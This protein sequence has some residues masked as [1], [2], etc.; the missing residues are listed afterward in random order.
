MKYDFDIVTKRTNTN[1]LKWGNNED[2][3]PMWVA[4]MDFLVAPEIKEAI[5][6]RLEH[7]I[8]GYSAVPDELY[9]SYVNWWNRRHNFKMK[10]EELLFCIGVMPAISSMIREFTK[11]DDNIIIQTP[12][13]HIFFKVIEDNNRNVLE[14]KL[15]FDGKNYE[16]DFE[17][18]EK[19]LSS[20]KSKMMLLCNPHNPIG[21]IWIKEEIEKIIGLCEKYNVLLVS[22]EIHCDLVDPDK[23]YIAAGR[24]SSKVITC[25]APTKTFNIAGIQSSVIHIPNKKLFKQ[26]QKRL[27]IDDS[28]QINVFSINATIAAF[29]DAEEWLNQLNE[30]IYHNK[31][32]VENFLADEIPEIRLIPCEA[33]Y[34][35]WLDCEKLNIKSNELS[36]FIREKTGLFLSPGR[37]FGEN[38][39]NFLRM[40][41]A[42]P[43]ETLL[44]G[45]KRLKKSVELLKEST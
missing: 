38:G 18:L 24:L 22:D 12:V 43:L 16:I 27:M 1:S 21:K 44:D 42:C 36:L 9:E 23:R 19:Q 4:D 20:E 39:D 5:K 33:T 41:I 26:M 30:Y 40:N 3:L 10:R 29:N 17:S 2:E 8:Y 31:K 37:Q 28:S 34:L 14:N 35:L 6:K 25:L 13:Y 15:L 45:L 7:G 11:E 32:I